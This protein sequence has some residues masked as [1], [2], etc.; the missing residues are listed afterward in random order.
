MSYPCVPSWLLRKMLTE[1]SRPD[2][3]KLRG[4]AALAIA[5]IDAALARNR[6]TSGGS[7]CGRCRAP[8]AA[9]AVGCSSCGADY[10]AEH[11]A[12]STAHHGYALVDGE[13][14][15]IEHRVVG[16]GEILAVR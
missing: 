4:D 15:G 14:V 16:H 6:R 5:Q 7:R 13:Q 8:I 10:L 2:T 9:T 11:R 1:R 3:A 12:Q